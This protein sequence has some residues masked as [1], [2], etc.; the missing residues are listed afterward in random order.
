MVPSQSQNREGEPRHP[1][2]RVE[3][4]LAMLQAHRALDAPRSLHWQQREALFLRRLAEAQVELD[5]FEREG[6]V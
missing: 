2:I 3:I 4:L 5:R 1:R 6:C